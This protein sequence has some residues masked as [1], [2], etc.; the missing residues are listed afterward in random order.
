[1]KN[2]NCLFIGLGSIGQR[3]LRN[4][5]KILNNKIKFYA[6]RKTRHVPLINQKGQK[7]KGSIEKKFN[8]E[9]IKKLNFAYKKN[10]DLVFITNPSS[11]H[12]HT[13]LSLKNLK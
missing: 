4:L 11:M 12:I 7:V 10:I 6:F 9:I 3:H 5:K 13:I 1:M 8:I 2:I